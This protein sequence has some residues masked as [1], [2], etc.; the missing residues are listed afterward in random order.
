MRIAHI[1]D[2]HIHKRKGL[3]RYNIFYALFKAFN[4]RIDLNLLDVLISDL[5][6]LKGKNELNH[7][8]ITGDITNTNHSEEF[9]VFI[10]KFKQLDDT[11][12]YE[13]KFLS[14]VPGNH[15]RAH[16]GNFSKKF[17]RR[18]YPNHY[19]DKDLHPI[20]K[21]LGND[22][23]LILVDST[24]EFPL[25]SLL[26]GSLGKIDRRQYKRLIEIL[27]RN[28]DRFKILALH[29]HPLIVPYYR[30]AAQ[31]AILRKA[32]KY[33]TDFYS[34]GVDLILHGHRHYPFNW[35]HKPTPLSS[36]K[37]TVICAP[38]V[39]RSIQDHTTIF[40]AY[41]IYQIEDNKVIIKQRGYIDGQY[42]W[43]EIFRG[44]NE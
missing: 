27:K 37:M 3:S 16:A 38:S 13:S 8:V 44:K 31:L 12:W 4:T 25:S 6:T 7:V 11:D 34:L 17:L 29:H 36:H 26:L 24:G 14:V 10:E 18:I 21:S 20:V 41:N 43:L 5:K 30:Q 22:I 19:K 23:G 42:K 28:K 33:L 2:I 32:R 39:A 15:D 40:N 1:S 9:E 35:K